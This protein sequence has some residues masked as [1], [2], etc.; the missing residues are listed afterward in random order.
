MTAGG[1]T[2]EEVEAHLEAEEK[3]MQR[4]HQSLELLQAARAAAVGG[5]GRPTRLQCLVAV[6]LGEE[7]LAS[8]EVGAAQ[9]LLSGAAAAYRADGWHG[10]LYKVLLLLRECAGRSGDGAAHVAASLEAAA[11]GVGGDAAQRRAL[12]EAALGELQSVAT[13][14]SCEMGGDSW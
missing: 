3:L 10:P 1:V 13:Q 8:G 5:D 9:S 12:A 11:L 6:A 4:G 2:D 7:L 14:Y